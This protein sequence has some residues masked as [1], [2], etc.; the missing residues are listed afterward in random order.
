M[1]RKI[2]VALMLSL[3]CIFCA[4]A[5]AGV[6]ETS[7]GEL[8]A[9]WLDQMD[10]KYYQQAW[11]TVHLQKSVNGNPIRMAGKEYSRGLGSHAEAC[12]RVKL[13]GSVDR[14]EAL[15]GID[16]EV[17]VD[18]SV[19]FEIWADG[20]L[21]MQ[22][23]LLKVGSKPYPVRVNLKGV[24]EVLLTIQDGGNGNYC[25]H[26]DWADARF[27]LASK[28][29]PVP[30]GIPYD[31]SKITYIHRA[32]PDKPE[33][34]SPAAIGGT[35]NRDF[36]YRLPVSGKR[37]MAFLVKN[38][39]EGLSLDSAT[40]I[41]TGKLL[42]AGTTRAVIEAQNKY[43]K[44]SKEILFISKHDALCL[45]PPMGW[46]SWNVWGMSVDENKMQTTADEMISSGLADFGYQ[47]IN[48][49]DG[50]Q[51]K[52]N[53]EGIIVP[54]LKFQDMK[55]L[56][57]YIHAKGLKF[58]IYSSPGPRTCGGLEG[59]YQHEY[60]DASTYAQWGVDYLKYDWC[61]Y[62]EISKGETKEELTK[63]Y[64]LMKKAMEAADRDIVFSLCQYGTGDVWKWGTEVGGH[65]WRTTGD[66]ADSWSSVQN[67]FLT[68]KESYPYAGPGH[69]NDPDMLVLGKLGWGP[70][71]RPTMLT[72]NEKLSHFTLWAMVASPLL[73]G[74]DLSQ[75]DP[76]TKDI[77]TH[78][79]VLAIN[80]DYPGQQAKL[81]NQ[82]SFFQVLAKPLSGNRMAVS[83]L[84]ISPLERKVEV[85]WNTL[86][87][88]GTQKARDA[89]RR[90]N[91]GMFKDGYAVSLP[92]HG[93][94]LL[95][96][97]P[98]GKK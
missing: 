98:A 5:S 14:F 1:R 20:K 26:A 79:E 34:H 16:D 3:S 46:N 63:P 47:Y 92:P 37:P 87:L 75:L 88:S 42:D 44:A 64:A 77:L 62:N 58:G 80:Q 6:T 55:A 74:C 66:I 2:W 95:V 18:G 36:L 72:D 89:W 13:K 94:V 83:L 22:S 49:D 91:L 39:P 61:S 50:W 43:G 53:E 85:K 84:N 54:N 31:I 48:I 10:L 96:L 40:G 4:W 86:G 32:I 78:E 19:V 68:Q 97:E 12:W 24:Q 45:T 76:L 82:S 29:S 52:R 23:P 38:L 59:S 81:I 60:Q 8:P 65:L 30:A 7:A 15:V 90:K 57:D 33:I 11:S 56:G 35:P 9:V 25:D 21:V 27:I 51:G 67:N 17:T 41:L 28:S 73:L 70:S 69:W 93:C 71:V